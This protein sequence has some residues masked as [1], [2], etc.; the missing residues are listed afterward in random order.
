MK[1]IYCL[2]LASFLASSSLV[3][4]DKEDG[5]SNQ[6]NLFPEMCVV[7][8]KSDNGYSSMVVNKG[9][10]IALDESLM[11]LTSD[12]YVK[13]VSVDGKDYL[14]GDVMT[15][16][17]DC[18]I[19]V[20]IG[21]YASIKTSELDEY[22]S[23]C[24]NEASIAISDFSGD[25]YIYI[26]DIISKH[27]DIVVDISIPEGCVKII[28]DDAFAEFD[29]VRS[30]TIPSDVHYIGKRAFKKA[31]RV[32]RLRFNSG[33]AK[34]LLLTKLLSFVKKDVKLNL[35]RADAVLLLKE[36]K[37]FNIY[38]VFTS[39][40][41]KAAILTAVL[42]SNYSDYDRISYEGNCFKTSDGLEL[43]VDADVKGGDVACFAINDKLCFD[44]EGNLFTIENGVKGREVYY[45]N[46]K[47][48]LSSDES[49]DFGACDNL[50]VIKTSKVKFDGKDVSFMMFLNTIDGVDIYALFV[51][52]I[53]YEKMYLVAGK[54]SEYFGTEDL[55]EW[56]DSKWYDA[57]G[58]EIRGLKSNITLKNNP[59]LFLVGERS[60]NLSFYK[61]TGE[62]SSILPLQIV[63]KQDDRILLKAEEEDDNSAIDILHLDCS[64]I[65]Q[66]YY[67]EEE[68]TSGLII[69]EEAFMECESLKTINLPRRTSEIRSKAFAGC[70]IDFLVINSD[71]EMAAD[72]FE[73]AEIKKVVINCNLNDQAM[74]VLSIAKEIVKF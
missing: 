28:P 24:S 37:D 44:K 17:S 32:G 64:E 31:R 72:A 35:N 47:F 18:A 39:D 40:S 43:Y 46:N 54:K 19:I 60:G 26:C 13:S 9:D 62:L 14:P 6:E 10:A 12:E 74:A 16:E 65:V 38:G 20:A 48:Y 55:I 21:K 52:E 66:K 58:K 73:D 7:S 4:C 29:N 71:V 69:A 5:K 42:K 50:N 1:K 70:K 25:A 33:P 49:T 57:Q 22:L 11:N 8:I 67:P 34:K 56:R 61:S 23:N 45:K 63:K 30:I 68:L 59:K 15:V 36:T 3:S 2:L 27:K 41:H 51:D 53:K